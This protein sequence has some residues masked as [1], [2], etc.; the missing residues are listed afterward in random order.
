MTKKIRFTNAGVSYPEWE[1]KKL[2]KVLNLHSGKDQ[3][4]FEDPTGKYPILATGGVIGRTNTPLCLEESV[5]IGRKGT[6]DKPQYMSTP[7]RTVDTL[8]YTTMKKGVSAR[9]IFFFTQTVRWKDLSEA[10]G[11]PSLNS[12]I[13]LNVKCPLPSL[14]EQ[15]KIA[16]LLSALDE[17]I[18]V[19]TQALELFKEQK[20]GYLQ[21]LFSQELRFRDGNGRMFPDWEEKKL[22]EV[23]DIRGGG[24]P[25]SNNAHYWNGE[26][27]WFTP[28]EV[29]KSKYVS[30]SKRRITKEGLVKSS[31]KELPS[32]TVLLTSRA[33]LGEMAILTEKAA[34]NQGFQ[35]LVVKDNLITNQFLYYCQGVIQKYIYR[36]ASGSTFLEISGKQLSKCPI[37]TPS[38][39]EQ[40]K[41]AD[42]LSALDDRIELQQEKVSLLKEQKTGYLQGIFG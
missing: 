30:S 32:G 3:K 23:A 19:E 13:I 10:T 15:E 28:S 16:G 1:E 27:N 36:T 7:F 2:G 4:G 12:S 39:T 21:K 18:S 25:D 14:P 38:L 40:Q 33:S 6:I 24:T 5:L 41:I 29:G 26:Y 8:F 42:F 22:G 35:N 34:T 17:S 31:A 20:K 11:V 9:Y 37:P